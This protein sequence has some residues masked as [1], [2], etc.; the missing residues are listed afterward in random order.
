VGLLTPGSA[1]NATTNPGMG[2]FIYSDATGLFPTFSKTGVQLCWKYGDNNID[3]NAWVDIQVFAIEMV[4]VP[5][6][7]FNVGTGGTESGSFTNG[8]WTSGATI[9]L[10]I[11][12][13]AALNI[14]Q[15]TGSLWGTSST[16]NNTIGDAGTLPAAFPKGYGAF[17]CMKYEISQQQYVDFLNN[18]KTAQ[19]S[20]RYASGSNVDRYAITV[21][22]WIY[23]T[24]NPYVACNN[25]SWGDLAAYLDWSGLRPMTELEFEKAC[26]GVASEIGNEYAWGNTVLTQN[27]NLNNANLAN[28]TGSATANCEYGSGT[29][30]YYNGGYESW[31]VPDGPA[32]YP[33]RVGVFATATSG[34]VEAGAT[35]YGILDMSGNVRERA[36]TVGNPEGRSFA[37]THG[38][39]E[40]DVTTGDANVTSWPATSA[41]GV[42]FRGGN[43]FQQSPYLR[44]SDRQEAAYTNAGRY[45][46]TYAWIIY[47]YPTYPLGSK[48]LWLDF[49]GRG[50]RSAP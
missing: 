40:L 45:E 44:V 31:W 7:A 30:Y 16:G 25:L 38:D 33:M 11:A 46:V 36:I 19:S 41:T 49:G 28:E 27:I 13:E 18:I 22:N 35:F 43:W 12:S 14:A 24:T 29:S 32:M 9:A 26:R 8:Y 2:A 23:S 1:Y 37:G 48:T 34:R 47:H 50:V 10:P 3:D 20:F 5:Q 4:F 15:S 42:G 39:G 17:Y 6:A 21:S